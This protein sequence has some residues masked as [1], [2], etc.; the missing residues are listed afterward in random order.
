MHNFWA[1]VKWQGDIVGCRAG[2][3]GEATKVR[4]YHLKRG[5]SDVST[6]TAVGLSA[7]TD[8]GRNES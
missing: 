8:I 6:G 7:G 5:Q 2:S 1:L 4:C 3:Q